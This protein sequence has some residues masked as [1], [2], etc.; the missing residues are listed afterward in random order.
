MKSASSGKM[1][2]PSPGPI[3]KSNTPPAPRT[4]GHTTNTG[5]GKPGC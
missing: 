2:K 4:G 1:S 5:N 3:T